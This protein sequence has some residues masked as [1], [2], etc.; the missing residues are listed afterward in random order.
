MM[1][2]LATLV[3]LSF[4]LPVA[5]QELLATQPARRPTTR[6]G[7]VSVEIIIDSS[8]VP[9]LADWCEKDLRPVLEKWYPLIVADLPSNGFT[10]PPKFT[11]VIDPSYGGVAATSSTRVMVSPV[12]IK[13][14]MVRLPWNEAIGSVVHEEVHV[15]QQYGYGSRRGGTPNP[16]WLVEGIA[17]YIRWFKY[18]PEDKRPHPNPIVR[19]AAA[20]G[21]G[22]RGRGRGAQTQPTTPGAQTQPATRAAQAPPTT[23]PANYTDSYRTTAAFLNYVA[24]KHDHEIVVKLNASLRDGRYR[25][26]LW[27]LY[28]GKTVEE[29]WAEYYETLKR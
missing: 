19:V 18:E 21:G 5:A 13:Q 28:T 15:V 24:D 10:P 7:E 3:V 11:V 8:Q 14:Q 20:G 2:V 26:E 6:P 16:V 1:H 23:R 22:R 4:T 12:W 29:L 17:D 9:E 25:P 27:S